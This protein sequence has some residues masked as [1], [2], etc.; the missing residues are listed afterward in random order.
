MKGRSKKKKGVRKIKVRDFMIENPDEVTA[1]FN[2]HF[3]SIDTE[4]DSKK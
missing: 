2:S 3:C 4:L 1:Y